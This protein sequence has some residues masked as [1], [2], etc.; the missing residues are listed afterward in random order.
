M[1]FDLIRYTVFGV[2]VF[3]GA[4]AAGTWAVRTRRINPFGRTGQL[5]RKVSD[6]VLQPLESYLLKRGGNPQQAGWWLLGISVVGGIL[7]ITA[8]D[9][10]AMTVRRTAR[11]AEQGV[12]GL[13]GLVV[14]YGSGVLLIA[15]IVR[16]VGSWLG[17]GPFNR[18]M[19]PFYVLTD[20][21]VKPL[22]RIV[23]PLGMI[24][25][26]PIIAW[27]LILL[28]RGMILGLL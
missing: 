17:L 6:P 14:Y 18:W 7:V 3:S 10:V 5:V 23:P 11:A 12:S 27:F 9:W 15:L 4:V 13:I 19:R 22:Q 8:M 26:T 21:I 25:I 24:D 1:L 28:L 2:F 16:V 20:W